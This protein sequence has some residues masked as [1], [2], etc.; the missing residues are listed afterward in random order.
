MIKPKVSK[1]LPDPAKVSIKRS[2]MFRL[3]KLIEE[4]SEETP[5]GRAYR[6]GMSDATVAAAALSQLQLPVPPDV[7]SRIRK[8]MLG[9]FVSDSGGLRDKHDNLSREVAALRKQT[10]DQGRL[11][12]ALTERIT[13]IEDDLDG[14]QPRRQASV[15]ALPSKTNGSR[16]Q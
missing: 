12:A 15:T 1:Q 3:G 8:S 16:Q 11:I 4:S 9:K 5:S 13:A 10:I 2:D 7:I 14:E 6:L